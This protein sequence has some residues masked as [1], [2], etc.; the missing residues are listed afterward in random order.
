MT[1]EVEVKDRV[2]G[3]DIDAFVMSLAESNSRC[4][5]GAPATS[6]SMCAHVTKV[7]W[8]RAACMQQQALYWMYEESNR[9]V[10]RVA[11]TSSGDTQLAECTAPYELMC[12]PRYRGWPKASCRTQPTAANHKRTAVMTS[13][14]TGLYSVSECS[15]QYCELTR[16]LHPGHLSG[17]RTDQPLAT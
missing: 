8:P 3:R 11:P 17:E 14:A 10:G 13:S 12:C 6:V 2:C 4:D 1:G 7:R 5:T 9:S 16:C 15:S